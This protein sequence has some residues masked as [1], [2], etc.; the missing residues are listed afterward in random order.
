[1]SKRVFLLKILT[2]GHVKTC[3]FVENPDC[4]V[5]QN[6]FSYGKSGFVGMS[7]RVFSQKSGLLGMSKR[8]FLSK[9]RIWGYV[10]TCLFVENPDFAVCQNVFFLENPDFGVCPRLV[11]G[12]GGGLETGGTIECRNR[13]KVKQNNVRSSPGGGGVQTLAHGAVYETIKIA[14]LFRASLYNLLG[15]AGR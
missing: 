4:W 15:A 10:K 9:I 1:M 8:V 2:C 11:S 5:F 13:N 7:K 12:Q 14:H 6:V 3:L